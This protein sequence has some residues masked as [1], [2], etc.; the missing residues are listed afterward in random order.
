[1]RLFSSSAAARLVVPALLLTACAPDQT[2]PAAN[3]GS[4]D[5]SRYVAVGDNYTAGY[6]EGGLTLTGQQYSIPALLDQQFALASGTSSS[7]T[8][9]LLPEGTGTGYLQLQGL[10]AHGLPVTRRVT[11]GRA[12]QSRAYFANAAACGGP[13][14]T[15]LYQRADAALP[16]NLGVPFLRLTQIEVANL[17]NASRLTTPDQFN[18]FLE[19][20]LPLNDSRTYLQTVTDGSANATFFTFFMGLSDVLP[21]VLSGGDCGTTP[22]ITLPRPAPAQK[23]LDKLTANGRPGIISLVPSV[24]QLPFVSR[25]TV[26]NVRPLLGANDTVYVRSSPANVVRAMDARDYVLPTGLAA[27]GTLQTVGTVAVRYG[28]DRRA[29][30][31]RRD[32]LDFREVSFADGYLTALNTELVRLADNVYKIPVVNRTAG[33]ANLF[34]QV[35]FNPPASIGIS[36]NG[37]TYSDDPVRGNFY[38]LDQYTFTPRGN[39]IF[40]NSFIREINRF[41]NASIPLLDPNT[42]PTTSRPR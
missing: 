11:R 3:P 6:S 27:L 30:L 7:F 28:L 26:K 29:P 39:A 31:S 2:P 9:P 42:L 1:M 37:V 5:F 13:D 20:I 24:T 41:Y 21:Y 22:S 33:G 23:I 14:T 17:G 40:V 35:I 36:I 4:L 12:T 38:S 34:S 25:G 16:Q 18:P 19:R 15:F 8:Q 32:V 10:D